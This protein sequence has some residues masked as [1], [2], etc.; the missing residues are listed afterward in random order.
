MGERVTMR[1]PN[2]GRDDGT[3][4][5]AYFEPVR[6]AIVRAVGEA[7]D[8]MP[9]AELRHHVEAR[10]DAGLWADA[11]VGWFTTTV[12]LHLEAEGW[13]ERFDAPQQLRLTDLGRAALADAHHADQR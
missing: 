7:D 5:R 1:N 13:L 8:G 11:S 4:S 10:T 6:D 12:K 2:T 3:I 9:F